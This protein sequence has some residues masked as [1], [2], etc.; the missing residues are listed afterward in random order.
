MKPILSH[1]IP[2]STYRDTGLK[3]AIAAIGEYVPNPVN[4]FCELTTKGTMKRFTFML[5]AAA[6]LLGGRYFQARN[7]DERREVFT[8][9]FSAIMAAV[10]TVPILKKFAGIFINKSVG[11]PIA[12]GSPNFWKNLNPESGKQ[13][14]SYPQLNEWFN[15]KKSGIK[16]GFKAFCRNIQENLGGNLIKCFKVLGSGELP[17]ELT[18]LANGEKITK[19]NVLGIIEKAD[20]KALKPLQELFGDKNNLLKKASRIKSLTEPATIASTAFL[21][22]GFLPWF[23]IWYTRKLYKDGGKGKNTIQNNT[24]PINTQNFA[25]QTKRQ[26]MS[27]KF[28]IFHDTGRLV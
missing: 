11:I 18:A 14:A 19:E 23:N 16:G 20:E 21:L 25:T 8:R 4:D 10:Y 17:K 2:K 26:K 7:D 6:T 28:Q 12:H 5:L 24:N 1:S 27:E 9:D 3:T 15:F 22:G 13:I